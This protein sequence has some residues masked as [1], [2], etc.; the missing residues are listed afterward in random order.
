MFKAA[1]YSFFVRKQNLELQILQ[2]LWGSDCNNRALMT[3]LLKN[4]NLI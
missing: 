4:D 3:T 2:Q 1:V